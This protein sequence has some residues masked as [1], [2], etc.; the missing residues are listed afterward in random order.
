MHDQFL[1]E[2]SFIL[3][4][5]NQFPLPDVEVIKAYLSIHDTTLF[6]NSEKH[7]SVTMKQ[8]RITMRLTIVV[9]PYRCQF[10]FLSG[11]GGGGHLL[12]E[13]VVGNFF[14]R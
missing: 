12:S 8:T 9:R 3:L 10:V 14:L 6:T 1:S 13:Y 7:N 2:Y 4:F 11:G 5:H